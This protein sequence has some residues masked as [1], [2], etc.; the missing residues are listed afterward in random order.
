MRERLD[1][2]CFGL[3]TDFLFVTRRKGSIRE[4]KIKENRVGKESEKL[5]DEEKLFSPKPKIR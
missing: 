5:I 2:S 3:A 4:V 1:N